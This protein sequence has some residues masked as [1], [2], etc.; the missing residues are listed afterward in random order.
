MDIFSPEKRSSVMSKI[1]GRNTRPEIVVRKM[2]HRLGF[3]FRL[4]RHDLPGSPDITLPRWKVVIF[5]HGCFW[6]RHVGCRYATTPSNNAEFWQKKFECN[7]ARD[8][9][10][11]Q[12]LESMGW[13]VLVVWECELRSATVLENLIHR[14]IKGG[15]SSDTGAE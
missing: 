3:R 7:I 15:T 5:V 12:Q 11:E 1:K 9:L 2:L 6:H 4:H 13:R 10:A 14:F 8:R